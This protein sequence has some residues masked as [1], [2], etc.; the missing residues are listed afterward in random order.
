MWLWS[1]LPSN[2]TAEPSNTAPSLATIS[3]LV[4]CTVSFALIETAPLVLAIVFRT[5]DSSWLASS[6]LCF[7]LPIEKPMPAPPNKPDFL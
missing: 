7:S 5:V 4:M 2:V 3:A 1:T 6:I